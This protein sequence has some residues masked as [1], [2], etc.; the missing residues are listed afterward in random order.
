M[1]SIAATYYEPAVKMGFGDCSGWTQFALA[2]PGADDGNRTRV[3]SLGSYFHT[4]ARE[5]KPLVGGRP[6]KPETEA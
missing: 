6:R 1:R 5:R 2:F 3:F 4:R